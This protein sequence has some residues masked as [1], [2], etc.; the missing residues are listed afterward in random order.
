VFTLI[1]TLLFAAPD[2]ANTNPLAPAIAG[3]LECSTPDEQRKTC[4]SIASY[5]H[6]SGPNYSN[7]AV[8][9]FSPNGP[10]ILQVTSPVVVKGN[11]VCAVTKIGDIKNGK[12]TVGGRKLSTLEAAPLLDHLATHMFPLF[13]HEICLTFDDSSGTIMELGTIDGVRQPKGDE[14]VQWVSPSAGYKVAP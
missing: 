14:P 8:M 11:A 2:M 13:G 4:R 6:L 7:T 3:Q 12:V 10:T 9:L 1:A 5:R